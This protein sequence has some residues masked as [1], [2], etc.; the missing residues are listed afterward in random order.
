MDT[1]GKR[2]HIEQDPKA[3]VTPLGQSPFFI[4]RVLSD[5]G[6]CIIRAQH[7]FVAVRQHG[8]PIIIQKALPG[9]TVTGPVPPKTETKFSRIADHTACT[10]AAGI[11]PRLERHD[12]LT[13]GSRKPVRKPSPKAKTATDAQLGKARRFAR[14]SRPIRQHTDAHLNTN[15][16]ARQAS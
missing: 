2:I 8:S 11:S 5:K 15:T 1:F 13:R 6:A 3:A 9:T 4:R 10:P 7:G 14:T 12:V 16:E